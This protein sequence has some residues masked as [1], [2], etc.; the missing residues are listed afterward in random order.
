[1]ESRR[2]CEQSHRDPRALRALTALTV[3]LSVDEDFQ[4]PR[5]L[6]NRHLQSILPSLPARRRW[7]LPRTAPVR[8]A[9][10]EIL[11]DC[12][13]GVRL[14]CFHSDPARAGIA[15]RARIAV[16]LHGWEGNSDALYILSLA[17]QLFDLGFDVVRLNLRDH[18]DTHHLN[19]EI[20]HSC[21]LPEVVGALQRLQGLL[22][23]EP[24]HLIGYSLG[25]NFLLR[26]A[27]QADTGLAIASVAA[28][29]PVIDPGATLS[30]LEN[31]FRPYHQY[32]VKKW[33]G[34]LFKKQAAWPEHY[35]F[36]DLSHKES[37]RRLTELMLER[38]TDFAS[39][40]EYLE[41]YTITGREL[42]S[43]TVPAMLITALD[44]PIIPIE[45]LEEITRSPALE[46]VVTRRGGHCGF[47]EDLV[48]PSWAERR[49]VAQLDALSRA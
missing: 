11:L 30:A 26:A 24:L 34:S 20:F 18:G 7:I 4:P 31:G 39:L 41:G 15:R 47:L 19:R 25:G 43:L 35:D 49:I 36:T 46:V 22:P 29:S 6:R 21:R 38:F 14:Q 37:L 2:Q 45:G 12:G 40:E 44:D 3:Q 32:F 33:I 28:V 23:G 48:R 42:A 10:Q 17:Q 5:W 16:L 1:M 27:A 8:A 9:S 13:E